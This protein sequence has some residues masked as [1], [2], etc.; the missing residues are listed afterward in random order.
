[1]AEQHS[2]SFRNRLSAADWQ[3]WGMLVLAIWLLISPW[4]FP[5]GE[6]NLPGMGPKEA[7]EISAYPA[8]A[9][10]ILAAILAVLAI[11]GMF[12]LVRVEKWLTLIIGVFI[13][14]APWGRFYPPD[15]FAEIGDR[16]RQCLAFG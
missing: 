16:K 9:A 8:G 14:G 7:L 10:R 13:A 15:I 6:A 2:T 1:M 12:R 11:S 4:A 5:Y 3:D